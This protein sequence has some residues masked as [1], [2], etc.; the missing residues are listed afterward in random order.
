MEI[1]VKI[2]GITPLIC[3]RFSD[4]AAMK[5]SNG[6]SAVYGGNRGTPLEIATTKLYL[7]NEGKYCIPQPNLLRCIVDGGSFHK[8]G[9]KQVTTKESS[10]LYAC[11]DIRGVSI[12]IEHRQPWRVDT[13]PIVIP[14]TK[15]R[16]LAHRPMFDDWAL[17][18]EMELDDK[19]IDPKFLRSIVDDAGKRIGLGDFRPSRKGPYGKFV[20][21]SWVQQ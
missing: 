9:K 1:K 7:D 17:T 15:G 16:V 18:F 3:N 5:A 21:T 4:E 10:I 2:E 13:R 19:M 20:M 8:A 12:K 11:L 6:S 14:S